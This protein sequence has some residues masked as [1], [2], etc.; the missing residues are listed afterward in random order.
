M[1]SIQHA[2]VFTGPFNMHTPFEIYVQEHINKHIR[3][4]VLAS[5]QADRLL[6]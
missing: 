1:F 2:E 6:F 4:P 5:C 3:G